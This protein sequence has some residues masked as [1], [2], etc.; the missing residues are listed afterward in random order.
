MKTGLVGLPHSGGNHVYGPSGPG[1]APLHTY[2]ATHAS[3]E[4]DGQQVV[5]QRDRLVRQGTDIVAG[6]AEG[7]DLAACVL[8]QY[9]R[10]EEEVTVA[11]VRIDLCPAHPYR[12]RIRKL[13]EVV[14][15]GRRLV[16]VALE[17]DNWAVRTVAGQ[18]I[19]TIDPL[20]GHAVAFKGG[21]GSGDA[22]DAVTPAAEQ[23]R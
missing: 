16:R 20:K 1:R 22:S 8:G 2:S 5:L 3:F 14:K 17:P 10:V 21:S 4:N 18:L 15:A 6:I 19:L 13:G 23:P 7:T 12:F 11:D 9:I